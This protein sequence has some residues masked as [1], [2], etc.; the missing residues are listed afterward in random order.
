MCVWRSTNICSALII[1]RRRPYTSENLD[2]YRSHLRVDLDAVHAV[3]ILRRVQ[4]PTH[5]PCVL[6]YSEDRSHTLSSCRLD[7]FLWTLF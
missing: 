6:L 4:S 7:L 2:V 3:N 5:L 1:K